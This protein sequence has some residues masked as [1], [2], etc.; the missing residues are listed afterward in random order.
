MPR[1]EDGTHADPG[2]DPTKAAAYAAGKV[3]G[4]NRWLLTI[5]GA[6]VLLAGLLALATPFVASVT[7]AFL[8][9]A[10]LLASGG[11]GLVAAATRNSGWDMAGT[12]ALALLAVVAGLAMLLQPT[13]GILALSTLIGAYLAASGVLRLYHGLRNRGRSGAGWMIA[14]GVLSVLLAALLWFGF[15]Y[16]AAWLPGVVL[17][18]DLIV[19]GALLIG[20]AARTAT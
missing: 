8:F 15:P 9:G 10:I 6:L 13:A 5:P 14:G 18:I 4:S 12:L 16:S 11:V 20:L 3:G 7:A 1:R 2:A 17:G 19:W